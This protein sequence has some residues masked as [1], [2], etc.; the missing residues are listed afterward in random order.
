MKFAQAIN[1]ARY[2]AQTYPLIVCGDFNQ[3]PD[4]NAIRYLTE[5]AKGGAFKVNP[6]RG[7]KKDKVY[8]YEAVASKLQSDLQGKFESCYTDYASAMKGI[9]SNSSA[10]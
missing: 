4:S 7:V 2:C 9:E 10:E 6:H 1:V 5:E 8:L 3:P